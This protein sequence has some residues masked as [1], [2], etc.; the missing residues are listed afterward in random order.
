MT[1]GEVLI[2]LVASIGVIFMLISAIGILRLPDVFM[3]MH[4][5]GKAATLGVSCV[6]LAAGIYYE[7]YF[8]RML[9]LI[10]L[11][12]VTG[13]IAATTLARA[14]YRLSTTKAAVSLHYDELADQV[15]E[16]KTKLETGVETLAQ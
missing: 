16:P 12:F 3:R 1:I 5:S 2:L 7:H 11:F 14:V 15:Q 13:P 10:G 6:M 4:A 9:L 8:L